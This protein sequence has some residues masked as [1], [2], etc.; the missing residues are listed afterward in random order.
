[1]ANLCESP[2]AAGISFIRRFVVIRDSYY[3]KTK[4]R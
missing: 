2:N 3:E 1:M 4:E